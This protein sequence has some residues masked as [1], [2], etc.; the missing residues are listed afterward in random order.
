MHP[1]HPVGFYL[2]FDYGNDCNHGFDFM[3]WG[4][5]T[6]GISPRDMGP[7]ANN[8]PSRRVDLPI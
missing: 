4:H 7:N 3:M 8:H 6:W 5:F 2:I 1:A